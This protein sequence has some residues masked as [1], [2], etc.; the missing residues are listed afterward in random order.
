MTLQISPFRSLRSPSPSRPISSQQEGVSS[1]RSK[2]LAAPLWAIGSQHAPYY[3]I[4][5]RMHARGR[6]IPNNIYAVCIPFSVGQF[7]ASALLRIQSL[8]LLC[9]DGKT[10][11]SPP[12]APPT[13]CPRIEKPPPIDKPRATCGIRFCMFRNLLVHKLTGGQAH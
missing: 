7:H 2:Y 5:A 11:S 3:I 13:N 8:I 12:Q 10:S 6:N 4:Y 9:T 1:K